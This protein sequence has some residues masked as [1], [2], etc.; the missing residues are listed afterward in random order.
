MMFIKAILNLKPVNKGL[1]TM[2]N[3]L[4]RLVLISLSVSLLALQGAAKASGADEEAQKLAKA[5]EL[6]I[7]GKPKPAAALLREVIRSNPNSAQAHTELGKALAGIDDT[8]YQQ[9]IAE[10]TEALRLDPKSYGARRVLGKIYAN[11]HKLPEAL[12]LLEEARDLK[13]T[14]YSA[15]SDLGTAYLASGKIDEAI[16]SFKKAIEIKPS[17]VESHVKLAVLLS[18]KNEYKEAIAEAKAAVKL[19]DK[20]AETHLTLA[21]LQLESGD[22]TEAVDAFKAAIEANGFDSFGAK[23]PLTAASALSGLGWAIASQKDVSKD[24]LEEAVNDE[25][26]AIKA[27]PIY[28]PGFVRLADLLTR[29]S[30]N[31]EA[32]A[33]YQGGMKISRNDPSIATPYAKFLDYTGHKDDAKALLKQ[34]L[35]KTPDNK[36]AADAL[37]AIEQNKTK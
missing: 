20:Q 6:L 14:S 26:K 33:V 21:N 7:K 8:N 5:D 32:E 1:C 2:G 36:Q 29:Q 3:N 25:R 12:K 17:S 16:A 4:R 11:Q 23:N 35:A 19:N 9:A 34:I 30:K 28:L 15:Q 10:E 37:A 13:P 27:Y 24:K 22:Y 18:K 31:K